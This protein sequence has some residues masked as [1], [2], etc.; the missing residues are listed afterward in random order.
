VKLA[1][2]AQEIADELLADAQSLIDEAGRGGEIASRQIVALAG[3]CARRF[4]RIEATLNARKE[5]LT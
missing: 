3:A 1:P 2:R 4:A 5:H